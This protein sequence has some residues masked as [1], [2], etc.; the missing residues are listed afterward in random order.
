MIDLT[1]KILSLD[2]EVA[3]ELNNANIVS[4]EAKREADL[5]AEQQIEEAKQLFEKQKNSEAK[6]LAKSVE[7]DRKRAIDNVQQKMETFDENV[8]I[9]E[10]VEYLL[11]VAK[12]RICR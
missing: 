4:M 12:D 1:Q 2:L 6:Q 3:S 8:K 9:D 11:T 10:L 7:D 5:H